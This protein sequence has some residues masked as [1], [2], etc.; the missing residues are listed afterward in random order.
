MK[1][2]EKYQGWTNFETWGVA[3]MINNDSKET[4][5]HYTEMCRAAFNEPVIYSEDERMYNAAEALR[6]AIWDA[7]IEYIES[8][9]GSAP[10]IV[11]L[12]DQITDFSESTRIDF[13]EIA[14][15]LMED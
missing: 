15:S 12:V 11:Q 6:N 14:K 8:L 10:F 5:E 4:Q 9:E 3:L 13:A 7:W 1:T 2:D